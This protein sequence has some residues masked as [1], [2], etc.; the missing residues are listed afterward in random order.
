MN[1]NELER[2]ITNILR[3]GVV[4]EVDVDKKVCR[5]RTGG[6]MTDWIHWGVERAGAGCAWWAPSI[7]EQVLIGAIGG[8]LTT[9]FILCSLYSVAH[10][11]PTHSPEAMHQTFSDGAVIEYEPTT[12]QLSVTGIKKAVIHASHDI[13]ATAPMVIVNASHQ[14]NF[15]TPKVVC[16]NNLTCA[17]LNVVEGGEMSGNIIHKGGSMTSNG[18]TLHTHQHGGIHRGDSQTDGP[19]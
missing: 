4:D 18:I 8:E 16:S 5:V 15:N 11:A 17:T 6:N 3:V 7:G 1:I 14:I 9:A 12:G 19:Q 2:L 13:D 10:D